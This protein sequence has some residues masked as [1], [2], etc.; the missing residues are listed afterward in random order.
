MVAIKPMRHILLDVD[1][2]VD[3]E[4]LDECL[5]N[6][7]AHPVCLQARSDRKSRYNMIGMLL[8]THQKNVGTNISKRMAVSGGQL[9]CT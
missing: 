2:G 8:R 5:A 9:S 6:L 3:L 1:R 7:G 4:S